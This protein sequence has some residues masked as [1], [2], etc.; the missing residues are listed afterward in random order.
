MKAKKMGGHSHPFFYLAS[1]VVCGTGGTSDRKASVEQFLPIDFQ[2]LQIQH[3]ILLEIL[4]HNTSPCD[5][6][7]NTGCFKLAEATR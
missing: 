1:T 6:L 2:G 4:R 7:R 5:S 3:V